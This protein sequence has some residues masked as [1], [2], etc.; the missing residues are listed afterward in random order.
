M[1]TNW[2]NELRTKHGKQI[3]LIAHAKYTTHQKTRREERCCNIIAR[4]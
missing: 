2:G 1:R 4:D 3:R